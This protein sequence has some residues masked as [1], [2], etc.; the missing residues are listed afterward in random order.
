LQEPDI[1]RPKTPVPLKK[2]VDQVDVELAHVHREFPHALN[3]GVAPCPMPAARIA[4]LSIHA[5]PASAL[6]LIE[7]WQ[8]GV[9][10]P[11]ASKAGD[12]EG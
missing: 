1:A 4:R 9:P 5:A 7:T 3:Q 6:F 8:R 10:R 2:A 11:P 12:P